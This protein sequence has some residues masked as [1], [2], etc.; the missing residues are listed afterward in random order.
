M[1]VLK[2]PREKSLPRNLHKLLGLLSY[3]VRGRRW[4]RFVDIF[5]VKGLEPRHF[6]LYA[7]VLLSTKVGAEC[8]PAEM[9][10]TGYLY[11]VPGTGAPAQ[12]TK[13]QAC[14]VWWARVYG[15]IYDPYR[16]WT[17][18]IAAERLPI[19]NESH[20]V[21]VF[22]PIGAPR[23]VLCGTYGLKCTYT[24]SFG[25]RDVP[26]CP[27][28]Y[29]ASLVN[30]RWMCLYQNNDR[31]SYRLAL[32]NRSSTSMGF[33]AETE[34]AKTATLLAVVYDQNGQAIPNVGIRLRVEAVRGSGGHN[35]YNERP[36]GYLSNGVTAGVAV[37]GRTGADGMTF[38][39]LAP[40]S[41]GD[42]RIIASCTDK[43]CKQE[44]WDT[45]WVGVKELYPLP[46]SP[47]YVLISPNADTYHPRNHYLT[48]SAAGRVAIL[49]ALY[50]AKLPASPVLHLN[51]ASLERGGYFDIDYLWNAGRHREHR[52]G[53]VIDIRANDLAGAIPFTNFARFEELARRVGAQAR[54]HCNKNQAGEC[55]VRTRHFHVRLEERSE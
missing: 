29:S 26:I 43:T 50:H 44:G 40:A 35:H 36:N 28:G 13:I 27:S 21:C 39:F 53:S 38:T 41:A 22:V 12:P 23:E 42:H 15:P 31:C 11:E 20:A 7:A 16:Y 37:D 30:A 19:T 52:R 51:D 47:E 18:A 9:E 25:I 3:L 33:L 54:V 5:T 10:P 32:V 45:V 1:Q 14:E 2:E 46:A 24:Y 48:V 8:Y 4:W 49:A 6:L 17:W 55:S 34:P